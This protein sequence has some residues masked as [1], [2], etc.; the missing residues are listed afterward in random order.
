MPS[1]KWAWFWIVI[2]VLFFLIDPVFGFF[3][4]EIFG[5]N[6]PIGVLAALYGTMI[7]LYHR[8]RTFAMQLTPDEIK[9]YGPLLES[10]V[11]LIVD[12]LHQKIPVR[13]IAQQVM[14]RD[15]VPPE[16]TY[17]YIIALGKRM[18]EEASEANT[19]ETEPEED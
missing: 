11:P 16:I 6:F 4:F 15:G 3:E 12:L 1:R 19:D 18:A 9:A 2:G 13:E 14:A 10:A 5:F 8:E 7:Y 17:K